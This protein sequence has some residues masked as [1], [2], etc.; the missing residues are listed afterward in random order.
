MLLIGA[1]RSDTLRR[2]LFGTIPERLLNCDKGL[3]V[4][5]IRAERSKGRRL[6][7][8]F[9]RMIHLTIPQLNRN[10]RLVLFD[11]G[12]SNSQWN[13][14][15]AALMMLATEIAGMRLLANSG[16]VVIGTMLV[17]PLIMPLIGTGLRAIGP[18]GGRRW[19]LWDG[20]RLCTQ[21]GAV[22]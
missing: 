15:F 7:D 22:F 18:W 21:R 9:W 8:V 10:E 4:E 12:E 19:A 16:A 17:A 3:T 13:F 2:K 5:V 20:G 14:D 11:D 6:R 1:S